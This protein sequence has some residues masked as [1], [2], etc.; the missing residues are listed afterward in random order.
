MAASLLHNEKSSTFKDVTA[1]AGIVNDGINRA[2]FVDYDHD[3]DLDLLLHSTMQI[4]L[5]P[6]RKETDGGDVSTSQL[7]R[8][9]ETTEM[10]LY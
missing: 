2:T 6:R 4:R 9:G 7:N 5:D 3:G 10:Q 8:F 1:V